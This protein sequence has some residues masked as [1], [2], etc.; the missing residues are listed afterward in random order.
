MSD[1]AQQIANDFGKKISLS[2]QS[3]LQREMALIQPLLP[4]GEIVMLLAKLASSMSTCA[5]LVALQLR[6]DDADASRF[7]DLVSEQ[8]LRLTQLAKPEVMEIIAAIDARE[9]LTP[10]QAEMLARRGVV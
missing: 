3:Q 7:F 5:I 4:P 10:A 2:F 6:R 9:A 1:L 8:I